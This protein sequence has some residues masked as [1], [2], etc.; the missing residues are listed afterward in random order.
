MLK[1]SSK[2]IVIKNLLGLTI[3]FCLHAVSTMSII[4]IQSVLNQTQGLGITCQ[5]VIFC[6]QL[7]FSLV[8][9]QILC[10]MIGFKWSAIIA[11]LT[12]A[13]Y[14]AANFY[15]RWATLMPSNLH[16]YVIIDVTQ[17]NCFIFFF[18][19]L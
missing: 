14:V 6:F 13:L 15:P 18:L 1:L 8:L 12:G 10:E 3:A 5:L 16:I 11:E 19:S 7:V 9:P 2:A 17:V 4:A